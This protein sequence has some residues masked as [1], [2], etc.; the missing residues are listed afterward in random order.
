MQAN[1]IEELE[2]WQQALRFVSAV[3]AVA[4]AGS[5][6]KDL[7][8]RAQIDDCMDSI[9]SNLSEGFEQGTDR[10]FARYPSAKS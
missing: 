9:L 3:S 5:L 10:A 1:T 7:R 8:L 2:V 4:R 6:G